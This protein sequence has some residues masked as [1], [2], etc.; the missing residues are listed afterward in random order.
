[1]GLSPRNYILCQRIER[2]KTLLISG[3]LPI[4]EIGH[5]VGFADQGYFTTAF[6]RITGMTP[7]KYRQRV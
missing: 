2:A 4:V 7:K 1:M 6:R 3:Q 5:E